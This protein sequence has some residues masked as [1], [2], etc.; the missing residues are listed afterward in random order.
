[1][2][3]N[4][5]FIVPELVLTGF[6]LLVCLGSVLFK[7][8][9]ILDLIALAGVLLAGAFLPLS[10][11]SP[12]FV[13]SQMLVNDGFS[14]FFRTVILGMTGLMVLMTMAYRDLDEE[15]RGEY[16]F[17]VL[18]I[19]VSMLLAVSSN[20]LVMIYLSLEAVSLMSY[21]LAGYLKREAFS[22]EAG[23][24][25]FL[26]GAVSTGV[27]LYGISLIYGLFGTLDLSLLVNQ[28]AQAEV[29][30]NPLFILALLLVLAG[31][32]FKCSL[33]PFHMWTPDVY[34]GAPTP[35]AAFFSVA[36]KAM[37]FAFLLRVFVQGIGE[38]FLSWPIIAVVMAVAT[39]TIGNIT[40]L[41]QTNIKR[42]LAYSTIAQAGYM[43]VGLAIP[44]PDGLK[45]ILF[46]IFIYG[47]MNLGAF[48]GVIAAYN[49]IKSDAIES[50]SGLYKRAP[51]LAV[52]LAIC[53]LSL[54]GLPPL[55]GF[56]AKFFI[57]AT[58]VQAHF[59]G[60]AIIIVINSVIAFYYYVRIIKCMFLDAPREFSSASPSFVSSFVL[61]SLCLAIAFL[62]VW[63][64]PLLHWLG[65]LLN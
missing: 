40:A 13:F 32:G 30:G 54:A 11:Q 49:I 25:Y 35:A 36:P 27:T 23:V 45:A 18:S 63:P 17:F 12:H 21:I 62:G 22:S 10:F 37:G 29:S 55:A 26:F 5:Q 15:D 28:M 57:I 59:I 56:L 6:A 4:L 24:K 60:L 47:L 46:Y 34:Q 2:N 61:L 16:H 52:T 65:S 1:M 20:N 39:M 64:H 7:N 3:V 9:K 41:T 50:Y 43:L 42:L 51:L 58:A 19:A 8:K 44:T 53:L 33:V 14:V 38:N 48:A 31:F